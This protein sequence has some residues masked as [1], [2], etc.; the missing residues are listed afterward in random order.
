MLNPNVSTFTGSGSIALNGSS[1]VGTN[2]AYSWSVDSEN[3]SLYTIT[4]PMAAQATLNLGPP[5][6][7]GNVTVNL[8]VTSGNA[9]DSETRTILHQPAVTNPWF[10]LGALTVD[11]RTL[12][13][14]DRVN[15]RT[16][17]STG[18][19][20]FWPTTPITI[21]SANTGAAQWPLTLGNAVNALNGD[22]RIGV[23]NAQNQVVPAANATT[24]RVFSMTSAN[25]A[26]AFLQ[27]VPG[28]VP[29]APTNLGATPG[30]AQVA[31]TWSAASG[32]TGYNVKRSTTNGGPYSNVAT[33]VAGRPATPTRV[34]RTARLTTTS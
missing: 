16:V 14:G 4:N 23:L 5:Q 34:S 30:N 19:D 3:P 13:V 17:S 12:V 2:L 22:V 25:I 11:P 6:A 7:S 29:P 9:S 18:Q 28:A 21:T 24:N 15:V 10:D 1:S 33:N 27:I 32:A 26:S 20:A 31:L 8:L